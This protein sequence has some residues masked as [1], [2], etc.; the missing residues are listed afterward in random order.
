[1]S[2]VTLDFLTK[3]LEL[4]DQLLAGREGMINPQD[5]PGTYGR[6]V[7][8]IDHLLE[9]M[10]CEAVVGGG[11][12]VWRHGYVGRVT[13][14]IDVA[15]PAARIDEFLRVA[16]VAGFE[17][18]PQKT[19]R[20]PKL[21]HKETKVKVD[22]LPEGARPGTA[23]DP[24]PTTIPSPRVMG[25]KGYALRYMTLESLVELKIAAGRSRDETDVI[26]VLRANPEKRAHLRGHL[27]KIHPRYV[28]R[29]DELAS[30]AEKQEDE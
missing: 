10:R 18:M 28:T 15:L 7:K 3:Q 24:A 17:V 25:A 13:Q 12:A 29:F 21:F 9:A 14:D 30:R 6:V 26:E 8:A 5:L 11:W 27:E 4:A 16:A 23:S 20:W 19:G 2:Q 22:I 1:V